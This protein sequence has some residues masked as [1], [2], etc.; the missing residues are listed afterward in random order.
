MLAERMRESLAADRQSNNLFAVPHAAMDYAE[1]IGLSDM[2]KKGYGSNFVMD[3]TRAAARQLGLGQAIDNAQHRIIGQGLEYSGVLG[4]ATGALTAEAAG[5][6]MGAHTAATNENERFMYEAQNRQLGLLQA[7]DSMQLQSN[8]ARAGI[9]A[10][11]DSRPGLLS[12]IVGV[13]SIFSNFGGGK[14]LDKIL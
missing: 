11:L 1:R 8:L 5:R 10:Q 3:M 9:E 4:K 7:Q 2:A 12:D 13:S 6:V 14:L